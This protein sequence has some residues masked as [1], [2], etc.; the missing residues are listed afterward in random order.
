MCSEL[1]WALSLGTL[2]ESGY[3]DGLDVRAVVSTDSWLSVR[4]RV[5]SV[6]VSTP[7]CNAQ[8]SFEVTSDMLQS[9]CLAGCT[10][11]SACNY[12]EYADE[13]DG[14]CEYISCEDACDL[15]DDGDGVCNEDEI[16]G[17]T[18]PDA[19]NFNA[20]ATD[21]DGSCVL[22]ELGFDC[23]GVCLDGD[24]DGVCDVDEIAGCAEVGA[25]NYNPLATED[26]G[27]CVWLPARVVKIE[28]FLGEDPGEGMGT[29]LEPVD[30]AWDDP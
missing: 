1:G 20:L 21:D 18:S 14:T 25:P 11:E 24:M 2:A 4:T 15:D 6:D 13:D 22:P 26:D 3:A 7:Y 28:Y 10:D 23:Q 29:Q 19:C 5:Y 9:G 27:S 8:A 30:G 16:P 12:S 17:C